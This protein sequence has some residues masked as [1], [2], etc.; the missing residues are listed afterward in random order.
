M[1]AQ[2]PEEFATRVQ[3]TAQSDF[4]TS[5]SGSGG[6]RAGSGYGGDGTVGESELSLVHYLQILYRRRY[7]A[8]TAFLLVFLGVALY[9]LTAVRVYE[10]TVRILIERDNPKVVSF[11]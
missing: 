10:G 2:I 1:S 5:S 9:T 8:T 4:L 11:Q 3:S 6:S 7:I